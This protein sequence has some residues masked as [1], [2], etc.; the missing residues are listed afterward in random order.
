MSIRV[1]LVDD[2]S[3]VRAG[4]RMLPVGPCT[5]T[6]RSEAPPGSGL[7]SSGAL[8]VATMIDAT[9]IP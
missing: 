1:L 6:T 5:L 2:Q 3:M 7:G 4:L 9:V 8:D